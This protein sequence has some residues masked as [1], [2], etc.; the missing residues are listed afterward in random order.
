MQA[1]PNHHFGGS[2][3]AA[4][5]I[6]SRVED[7]DE[8]L[9]WRGLGASVRS[10]PLQKLLS[11]Y[12]EG[13]HATDPQVVNQLWDDLDLAQY[14]LLP[15]RTACWHELRAH[16]PSQAPNFFNMLLAVASGRKRA[17]Y[18]STGKI[19]LLQCMPAHRKGGIS[20]PPV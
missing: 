17:T 5:E 16:F 4:Q 1:C 15:Q 11:A 10:E 9:K 20:S 13:L 8:P 7:A 14:P 6:L 18:G 12:N 3:S 2:S 19:S